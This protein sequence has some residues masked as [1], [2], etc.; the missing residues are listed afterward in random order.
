MAFYILDQLGLI[1]AG[2][3]CLAYGT[4][5]LVKSKEFTRALAIILTDVTATL[6]VAIAKKHR[7]KLYNK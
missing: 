1:T 4:A 3:L 5:R 6:G 2:I 7:G